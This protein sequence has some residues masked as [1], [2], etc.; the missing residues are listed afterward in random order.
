MTLRPSEVDDL[1]RFIV[2]RDR[3]YVR[4]ASGRPA[5][6]TD[7]PIIAGNHFTN[8]HRW[9]DPGTQWIAWHV[10]DMEITDPDDL[11]FILVAYRTLNRV[12][13]FERF[14]F[15][16]RDPRLA[17]EWV[18]ELNRAR[19]LGWKVGSR[20]HQTS[21]ARTSM[22]LRWLAER[23]YADAVWSAIDGVE[24][25]GRLTRVNGL[26]PF[27]A[28]QVVADQLTVGGSKL[29]L[30]MGDDPAT[31]LAVGSRSALHILMGGIDPTILVP[32]D[33]SGWRRS[34][35]RQWRLSDE[36]RDALRELHQ[37]QPAELSFPLTHVDIEHS[38]CEW[39]RYHKLTIGDPRIGRR[40]TRDRGA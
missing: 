28:I 29:G 1:W 10:L 36:E 25:V 24:A 37:S 13:T 22:S 14:G 38:L 31:S 15:P 35:A 4:R 17:W 26:G 40:V 39:N 34:L 8:V 12:A 16:P 7:D 11:L 32:N 23:D 3:V 9:R 21:L 2:E 6:W 27:Y 20:R 19:E 30:A 33:Q 18:A 5:P